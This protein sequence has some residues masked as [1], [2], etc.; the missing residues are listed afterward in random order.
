MANRILYNIAFAPPEDR[1]R[2]YQEFLENAKRADTEVKVVA[3]ERSSLGL[4]FRYYLALVLPDI[5]HIIRKAEQKG[6]DAAIIGC[7]NDPGLQVA[8]EMANIVVTAPAEASMHIAAT[9]GHKF[10]IIVGE[11][12]SIPPVM[13][14]VINYGLKA[15]LASFRSIGL[16]AS[17]LRKD[18]EE[19]ANRIRQAAREALEQ[20]LAEVIILGCTVLYGFSTEIQKSLGVPVIDPVLAAFKY[21]ELLIELKKRFHWWHSERVGF[22][23]PPKDRILT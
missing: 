11:A 22:E 16:R 3:L 12:E 7:F 21:A 1:V 19:T 8:K 20:D 5:L 4:N 13:E 9:L 2:E 6:Y 14:N 18:E 15:K 10:S 23:Q 17:E